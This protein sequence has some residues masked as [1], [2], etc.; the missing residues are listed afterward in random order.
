[1]SME[2]NGAINED[3][4]PPEGMTKDAASCGC[5]KNACQKQ[6]AAPDPEL[7]DHISKRLDDR[8]ADSLPNKPR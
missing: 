6:A 1:M 8:A 7:E 4:T 3:N 5:G 2:K